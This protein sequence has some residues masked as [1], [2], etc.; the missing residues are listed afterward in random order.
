MNFRACA[1]VPSCNHAGVVGHVVAALVA[2][3]LAVFVID[4]GS[5]PPAAAVL[6][7]LDDAARGV[8]VTRLARNGGKGVAVREGF[9]RAGAAGFS[10]ALQIDADGQHDLAVLPRMLALAARHPTAL[11]SGQA[12]FDDSV[13]RSRRIGRWV[14]HVWVH[15]ETLSLQITDSM[16]G[17]R[18]YPLAAVREV[19]GSPVIGRRMDFDTAIMV[20]LFW[21]GVPVLMVPVRVTYPP[22][23]S[24]NFRMLRDNL[25]ISWMH[26]VLVVMMLALLLSGRL[27]R[28][29]PIG[30][31]PAHWAALHELGARWGI[32]AALLIHRLLGRRLCLIAL[33]PVVAWF[34]LLAGDRRRASR[35]F[36]AA[37][38]APRRPTWA[39]PW[40]HFMSFAGR[41]LDTIAAWTGRLPADAVIADDPAALAAL[42]AD[43]RGALLIVGHLGN[44]DVS[45]ALLS[46]ATRAR[47]LVLTHTL[48]A[49]NYNQVLAERAPAAALD[50]LQVS[51]IGPD[52]AIRL[53]D[54]IDAG[55]WI[56]I[57]GDRTPIGGGTRVTRVPF[58]G[59]PAAFSQG[60]YVLA[61]LMECPVHLLFCR[62]EGARHLLFLEPFA[63]RITLPR[64][65][66][67]EALA[68]H[69]AR[70]ASRLEAHA[71][72]DPF[73]WY[74]FFDFWAEPG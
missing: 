18:I 19:I 64:A 32:R 39:D 45:R 67:A 14:T 11:I 24:S 73:Q 68:A 17:L 74:N 25:L 30:G 7:A 34:C 28:P 59:R 50:L 20:R 12:V 42:A 27:R 47:L 57:A 44:P 40:R 15:I 37:A 51:D 63:E 65:G 48:H 69:A 22:G 31:T 58:L 21:H 60:P 56:V 46:A 66:R 49:A 53:R 3:G 4:D 52:T 61:A 10:H 13:P 54:A 5:D 71:L 9:R 8:H 23:N 29:P 43:P 55:R 35:A 26:T 33:G 41:M 6:A 38:F 1:I 70:Y 16:C 36:L 2:L 72:A 62:R